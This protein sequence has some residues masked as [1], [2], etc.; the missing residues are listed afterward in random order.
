MNIDD[1]DF[2]HLRLLDTLLRTHSVSASARELDI[3]QPS[4]SHGLTRLR[5]ALQDPLLVRARGGMEPT[6]RA[7]ALTSIV[8]GLLSLRQSLADGGGAFSIATLEREFVIAGSDIAQ[9][10]V[11]KALDTVAKD[12]APGVRFRTLT[13]SGDEMIA[14]LETG[15]VDLAFGPY[16]RLVTGIRSQKLYEEEYACFA[17]CEH[18][19]AIKPSLEEFL[20]SDHV[21][22]SVRRLSHAHLDAERVLARMLPTSKMR[23]ITGSFLVAL[24]AASDSTAI[25]TAPRLIVRGLSE[26]LK[27]VALGPPFPIAGFEVKQYWHDRNQADP[28]HQW[29]RQTLARAIAR[30]IRRKA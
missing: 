29:L 14:A 15:H 16:P 17:G 20:S 11:L 8:E 13:L 6:P 1:L 3:P 2:K 12:E 27:L 4:A 25:L 18:P 23:I 7:V 21:I 24:A 10:A 9:F 22:V 28:A 5:V 30:M 26:K 19:F